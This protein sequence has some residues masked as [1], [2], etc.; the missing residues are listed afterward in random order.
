MGQSDIYGQSPVAVGAKLESLLQSLSEDSDSPPPF[1][2][3]GT[4]KSMAGV[5]CCP[6]WCSS[7]PPSVNGQYPIPCATLSVFVSLQWHPMIKDDIGLRRADRERS[8]LDADRLAF[9]RALACRG[10]VCSGEVERSGMGEGSSLS[11]PPAYGVSLIQ[12][13][14]F[15]LCSFPALLSEQLVRRRD[16]RVGKE[17]D[18]HTSSFCRPA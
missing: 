17:R 6:S 8:S 13:L 14:V 9:G 7:S 3:T 11:P 18:F 4:G 12:M 10:R 1:C 15:S 16:D 2:A 5:W